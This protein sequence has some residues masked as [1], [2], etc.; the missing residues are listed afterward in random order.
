ML[1]VEKDPRGSNGA[2][3]T[4]CWISVTPSATHNQIGPFWCCFPGG[5]VC[6]LS[7]PLWVCPTSSPVRLGVSPAAVP[8]P[9]VFSIR[10]LRLYFPVL[11]P[12]VA[13]SVTWSTSCCLASQLQPCP[14]SSTIRHIAGSASHRLAVSPLHLAACLRP[15]YLSR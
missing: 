7:R 12:W 11:E 4:L 10:A 5:W 2:C 8:T 1:Y 9:W 14:P 13:S 15:S 6:I 3:S